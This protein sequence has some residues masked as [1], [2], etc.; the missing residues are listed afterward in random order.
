MSTEIDKAKTAKRTE[1][2]IFDKIIKKEV[3]A[4]I[5][6]EDEQCL[7]FNDV[8]PQ[9]PV[10]FLVIPK[11][12]IPML[13]DAQS[14]DTQVSKNRALGILSLCRYYCFPIC[15][16]VLGH[17]L[18]TAKTLAKERLP[19]GYR[20]VINNGVQGCQSVYHLHVH[21]IGGRQMK[22]PPG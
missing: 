14:E 5:I 7:A 12:K 11:K 2:T 8:S 4:D 13:D 22:W 16:Q 18:Y 15:Q 17:L 21:V 1:I 19:K 9:G 10:H 3:K 6:Y 20:V